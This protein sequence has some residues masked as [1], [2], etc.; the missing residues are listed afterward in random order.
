M[1]RC[2]AV[3]GVLVLVT[4]ASIIAAC[5][6]SDGAGDDGAAP[7]ELPG[8]S[9]VRFALVTT[10]EQEHEGTID[11]QRIAAQQRPPAAGRRNPTDN[12]ATTPTGNA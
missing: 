2:R 12:K 8:Q 9:G 7:P 6:G 5:G 4:V 10:A 1:I 11:T 3:R